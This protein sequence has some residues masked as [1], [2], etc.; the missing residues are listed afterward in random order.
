MFRCLGGFPPKVPLTIVW[1]AL[2]SMSSSEDDVP[3]M[4]LISKA[5][6]SVKVDDSPMKAGGSSAKGAAAAAVGNHKSGT[7]FREVICVKGFA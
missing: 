1:R 4:S 7:T 6:T 2:P 5:D 3:L